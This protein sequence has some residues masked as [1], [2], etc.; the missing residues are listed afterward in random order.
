MQ[1]R[2]RVSEFTIHANAAED[3]VTKSVFTSSRPLEVV[4]ADVLTKR[5]EYFSGTI[6]GLAMLELHHSKVTDTTYFWRLKA[7]LPSPPAQCDAPSMHAVYEEAIFPP[8]VSHNVSTHR[9]YPPVREIVTVAASVF[10]LPEN[11]YEV[12]AIFSSVPYTLFRSVSCNEIGL[13]HPHGEVKGFPQYQTKCCMFA[14]DELATVEE[15]AD[16]TDPYFDGCA[17]TRHGAV[18]MSL[19]RSHAVKTTDVVNGQQVYVT[20]LGDWP[21]Q[22]SDFTSFLRDRMVETVQQA[23]SK[24]CKK[25][26]EMAYPEADEPPF[27]SIETFV[28]HEKCFKFLFGPKIRPSLSRTYCFAIQE[29]TNLSP[30]LGIVYD[31]QDDVHHA[32]VKIC[33]HKSE[34]DGCCIVKSESSGSSYITGSTRENLAAATTLHCFQQ[35]MGG[36]AP[37]PDDI[38]PGKGDQCVY[39]ACLAIYDALAEDLY[40]AEIDG[41]SFVEKPRRVLDAMA[42][43]CGDLARYRYVLSAM[44]TSMLLSLRRVLANWDDSINV[45]AAQEKLKHH[46]GPKSGTLSTPDTS[47]HVGDVVG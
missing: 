5:A 33:D 43:V 16:E 9:Y 24:H 31:G 15:Q 6:I 10:P 4:V 12:F 28:F 7:P 25:L 26:V 41:W 1:P 40:A 32:I 2:D 3:D 39:D 44:P 11:R 42:T 20:E 18:G 21:R 46:L 35:S 13:K 36:H 38:D 23:K 8:I 17:F 22:R 47:E 37:S 19:R 14:F 34:R 45:H 30:C 29:H 27:A